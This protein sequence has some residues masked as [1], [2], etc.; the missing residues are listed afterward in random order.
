[1]RSALGI[2]LLATVAS[3]SACDRKG[4][5]GNVSNTVAQKTV[6]APDSAMGGVCFTLEAADWS[7]WIDTMPGSQGPTL[8]VKGV[9]RTY[10]QD[11]VARLTPAALDKSK[12]PNQHVDFIIITSGPWHPKDPPIDVPVELSMPAPAEKIGAVVVDCR[13]HELLRITDIKTTS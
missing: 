3:L 10:A 6:G 11:W 1:M 7:A 4:P 2:A 12:P 8:H 13:G 5:D 9:A